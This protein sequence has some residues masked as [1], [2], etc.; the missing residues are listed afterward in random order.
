MGTLEKEK[1]ER[2]TETQRETKRKREREREREREPER[3]VLPPSECSSPAVYAC[4]RAH[5]SGC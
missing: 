3:A 4:M 2:E 5:Q 1:S